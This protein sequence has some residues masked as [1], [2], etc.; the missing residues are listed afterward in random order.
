M[1]LVYIPSD[2][3]EKICSVFQSYRNSGSRDHGS[4][5]RYQFENLIGMATIPGHTL[6]FG[7]HLPYINYADEADYK[8]MRGSIRPVLGH[9][10]PAQ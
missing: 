1:S 6:L 10:E 7:F 3:Q 8:G 5:R 2:D 4:D 9:S